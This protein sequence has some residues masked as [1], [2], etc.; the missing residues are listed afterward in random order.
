MTYSQSIATTTKMSNLKN[1]K[2][3]VEFGEYWSSSYKGLIDWMGL[4]YVP[5]KNLSHIVY[6]DIISYMWTGS[7][8]AV[9]FSAMCR[10]GS[11]KVPWLPWHRSPIFKV[12]S[13]GLLLIGISK[14]GVLGKYRRYIFKVFVRPGRGLNQPQPT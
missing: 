8:F 10:D 11:F 5:V 7:T 1:P 2:F 13:Q 4:N 14:C 9:H 3:L 12:S 6:R